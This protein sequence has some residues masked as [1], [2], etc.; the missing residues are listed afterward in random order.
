TRR[1]MRIFSRGVSKCSGPY[2]AASSSGSVQARK[3]ISRGASKMRVIRTSWAVSS[4]RGLLSAQMRI[5]PVHPG[6]PCPL[7]RLHP[8]DRV[9]QR[10]RPHPAR[11]PLRLAAA[12]DQPGAL[13]HF[14]VAR[15]RRKAHRE[16]LGELVH[17]GLAVGKAGQDRS[18]R[19]IGERGEGEAELVGG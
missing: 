15:D 17:G 9:I 6:I 3:T 12:D 5:E 19:R 10:L 7:A 16:W 1:S 18:A 13:E 8:L 4:I 14:E 2:H 11:A